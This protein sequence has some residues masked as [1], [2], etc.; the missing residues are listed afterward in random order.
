MLD[1]REGFKGET[2]AMM[3]TSDVADLG[4]IDEFRAAAE[5]VM[6]EDCHRVR[7]AARGLPADPAQLDGG[8]G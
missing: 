6:P 3:T 7:Q 2:M 4:E 5:R 8:D 1:E